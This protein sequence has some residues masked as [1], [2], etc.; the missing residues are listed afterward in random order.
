MSDYGSIPQDDASGSAT[1]SIH[2]SWG[3]RLIAFALVVVLLLATWAGLSINDSETTH[4]HV[5]DEAKLSSAVSAMSS[6]FPAA[7][8]RNLIRFLNYRMNKLTGDY[9]V[10]ASTT[11]YSN[12]M[13]WRAKNLPIKLSD[14]VVGELGSGK[15]FPV[16]SGS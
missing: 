4:V 8:T 10:A 7:S 5:I 14:D 6:V 12:H 11:M 16:S 9:D 15:F 3:G 2:R 13:E 1:T